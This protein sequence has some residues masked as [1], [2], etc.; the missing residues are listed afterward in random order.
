MGIG[1]TTT[2][3]APSASRTRS[4]PLMGIGNGC[5]PAAKLAFWTPHYPS[6]GL[7]TCLKSIAC[8]PSTP[9]HYPSWGLETQAESSPVHRPEP[10][11]PSW[12]LET[13]PARGRGRRG[14][15][16]HYPSWGLETG[17]AAVLRPGIRACSL[18]LMGIGNAPRWTCKKPCPNLITPHGDWK[19]APAPPPPAGR[20]RSSHYPSW[21]LETCSGPRLGQPI[22]AASLP[23]MGIGNPT[24]ALE[25]VA[26]QVALITPHGDWK[27]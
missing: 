7:E 20:F 24:I 11:Y 4:L 17:T 25:A 16:P 1:N 26:T 2:T 23:L 14:R 10:H 12:G 22:Y 3:T 9:T 5:P 19:P 18:P 21:G 15:G 6:W 8:H 27:L 13:R